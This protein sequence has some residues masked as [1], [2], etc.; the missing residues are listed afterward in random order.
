MNDKVT[1]V[2][3][4]SL[5]SV[6]LKSMAELY[7]FRDGL[8]TLKVASAMKNHRG[9]LWDFFVNKPPSLSAGNNYAATGYYVRILLYGKLSRLQITFVECLRRSNSLRKELTRGP[10][11]RVHT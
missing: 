5:H 6:I 3:S 8:E 4:V 1:L 11:K 7:Q 9:L 2:Q 10:K